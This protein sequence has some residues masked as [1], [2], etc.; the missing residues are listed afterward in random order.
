M[1]LG[2]LGRLGIEIY[3][4]TAQFTGDLGKAERSVKSFSTGVESSLGKLTGLFGG[5]AASLGAISFA[6]TI[7]EVAKM[8]AGLDDLSDAGLGSVE[9][10]SQLKNSAKAFNADFDGITAALSKMVKGLAGSELETSKAGEA[11]SRLGIQARDSSG[12]L[13]APAEIFQ[14]L[15]VKLSGFKDGADK[16]AFAQAILGKGGEK[17]LPVLKDMAEYGEKNATVTAKQAEEADKY[18]KALKG[19]Q[20]SVEGSSKKIAGEFIPALTTLYTTL[21]DVIKQHDGMK[22]A[23]NGLAQDG[24]FK[25]WAEKAVIAAAYVIDAFQGIITFGKA[26]G[27]A[28]GAQMAM[29][30]AY[31]DAVGNSF[32]KLSKGDFVGALG[33][34]AEGRAAILGLQ[35]DAIANI[36]KI[37]QG[38]KSVRVSL[39]ARLALDKQINQYEKDNWDLQGKPTLDS[40]G[41]GGAAGS[42]TNPATA[43]ISKANAELAKSYAEL[44]DPLEELTSA[45]KALITM[46]ESYDWTQITTAERIRLRVT[47]E[48]AAAM[49]K[50]NAAVVAG[51]KEWNKTV[52]EAQKFADEFK[53]KQDNQTAAINAKATA[54][55]TEAD[56]WGKLPSEIAAVTLAENE[57]ILA[58]LKLAGVSDDLIVSQETLVKSQRNYVAAL[59]RKEGI[60]AGEQMLKV[61]DDVA[62]AGGRFFADLVT[63][64]K[65]AF[66]RLKA[67]LKSFAADLLAMFAKKYILNLIGNLTGNAD[68]LKLAGTTGQG[69]V[70]GAF[71]GS[72]AGLFAAVA[73]AG[74]GIGSAGSK[75]LGA[76]ERG[77]KV[78][79]ITGAL[80]GGL[81]GSVIGKLTDPN[82]PANRTADFGGGKSNYWWGGGKSAFGDFGITNDKWFSDKDM[83]AAVQAFQSGLAKAEDAFAKFLKP[84]E[85]QRVTDALAK[86]KNYSFG[87]EHTDFS[88]TLGEILRDRVSSIFEA[89]DPALKKWLDGFQG[90]GDELIAYANDLLNVRNAL[91]DGS[92]EDILGRIPDLTLESLTAMQRAGESLGD[93]L[94]RVVD[95]FMTAQNNLNS[96][97]ASRNPQ[98]ARDLVLGQRNNLGAQF[99]ASIGRTYDGTLAAQMALNPQSFTGLNTLQMGM[100]AQWLGLQTQLEQLDQQLAQNANAANNVTTSFSNAAT[101]ADDYA[102]RLHDSQTSLAD[103]LRGA[104]FSGSS[105]LD[106]QAKYELA[107]QQLNQQFTLA[108]AGSLDAIAGLPQF[109]QQFWDA[110]QA[111]NASGPQYNTDYFASYARAAAL[112]GGQIRPFTAA[113]AQVQTAALVAALTATTQEQTYT[114]ALIAQYL[115]LVAS[116]RLQTNDPAVAAILAQLLARIG[117]TGVLASS[118]AL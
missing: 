72:T 65:S 102:A 22:Q 30:G 61:W 25:Q 48:S 27:E 51:Q 31:I 57:E 103:F 94:Q 100:L 17:F 32:A 108:D 106:P 69:S 26:V 4:D 92:L 104:M 66:D 75:A 64:G 35:K 33:A 2:S 113:D 52:D 110:S 20:I 96:A 42:A 62:T 46:R 50:A 67:S 54:I 81:V 77:Q 84:E 37:L 19:L 105:P 59:Q 71:M 85:I 95:D 60:A 9:S 53:K 34:S 47:L 83:L 56:N 45:E 6:N 43:M 39:E 15:A 112:T 38:Y 99:A 97:I 14:E 70:G 7:N 12:A 21:T 82:G 98:F 5:I 79:G 28:L 41:L 23:V 87:T 58:R 63:N 18:E 111:V 1:S 101:A 10:L 78:G 11:L 80:F 24:T 118:G 86:S 90:T 73:A 76:G 109:L 55:N 68:I 29:A 88:G 13:R 74:Y 49:Q 117:G 44:I 40:S 3:A 8:R 115:Q 91:S 107:R 114:N 116:G 93:T 36:D 89:I 16:A